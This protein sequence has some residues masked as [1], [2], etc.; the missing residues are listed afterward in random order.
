MKCYL[1]LYSRHF[2]LLS[3][4]I[5]PPFLFSTARAVSGGGGSTNTAGIVI[6][7]LVCILVILIVLYFVHRYRHHGATPVDVIK[8]VKRKTFSRFQSPQRHTVLQYDASECN[9]YNDDD[10]YD[11]SDTN[12][13]VRD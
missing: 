13:F 12:P 8:D 6:G 3:C 10:A 2:C 7:V 11:T 9:D 1:V 5:F 4:F